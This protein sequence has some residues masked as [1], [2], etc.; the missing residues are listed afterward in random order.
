KPLLLAHR[1]DHRV[2]AENTIEAFL[3]A[4]SVPGCSGV[5]LDVRASRDGEAVV[6]HDAT[7]ERVQRHR[8]RVADLTFDELSVFSVPRLA[9]VFAALP[10][11]AFVDVEL[12]EPVVDLALDVIAAARGQ[13]GAGTAI[14]SFSADIVH[15]VR[16]RQPT[17]R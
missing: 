1:G 11:D 2:E 14:S 16:S 3:A 9:D 5:E 7:L 12:K 10:G 8:G 17:W 13:A 6:V 15:E 4:M